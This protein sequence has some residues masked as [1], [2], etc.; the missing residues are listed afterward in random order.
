MRHRVVLLSWLSTLGMLSMVAACSTNSM[1]NPAQP[2]GTGTTAGAGAATSS[3]QSAS[4]A[5]PRP[6]TPTNNAQVKYF[7][8]PVTLV[9]QNAVVTRSVPASYTFEVATDSGFTNKVQTKDGVSEGGGGQTSVRLDS[10]L[11]SRDYYWHAR[12]TAGGTTGVF[13]AVWKF[14]IGPAV[15]LN[16]PAPLGPLTGAQTGVRPTFTIVNSSRTGPVGAVTYRFEVADNITFTP[17]F[18]AGTVAEGPNQ[19]S[20]TPSTDLTTNK[21]YYW[22]ATAIDQSH[23]IAT[24]PSAAQSFTA[25]SVATGTPQSD[26]AA[27]EGV[28]LWPGVQPPGT[29]G[30]AILGD[31]WGVQNL[32]SFQGIPFLS[33]TPE[34][35]QIFDLMDRGFDPQGAINWMQGNGYHTT[36]AYF[37]SVAV[38]GF[39]YQYMA[40]INGRWDLV[41]RVGA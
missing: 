22:R 31:G 40:Y 7:D 36:G 21:S 32:F 30:H 29:T 1:P 5:A 33:P 19:T 34:E 6:L 18:V 23:A 39:P 16:P 35:L 25:A 14:N 41:K 12:A 9:I 38:I 24:Q 11:E 17:I 13:G 26:I 37:P 27:Q 28:T 20:F 2:S 3:G 4:I 8:Q 15:T 10:L